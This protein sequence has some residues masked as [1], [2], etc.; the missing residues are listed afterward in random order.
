VATTRL[1][2]AWLTD[3]KAR[4]EA[5]AAVAAQAYRE[6]QAKE[7]EAQIA[8]RAAA[9][10]LAATR[11]R[12]EQ[13]Q[14][15]VSRLARD[16]RP[17]NASEI[18]H[19]LQIPG[20]ADLPPSAPMRV[21]VATALSRCGPDQFERWVDDAVSTDPARATRARWLLTVASTASLPQPARM[22]RP[23]ED[24]SP[25]SPRKLEWRMPE[26]NVAAGSAG[27]FGF[28]AIITTLSIL[29]VAL[30]GLLAIGYLQLRPRIVRR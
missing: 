23:H 18:N 21:A 27:S 30:T 10:Q 17:A 13:E 19:I 1:T 22:S 26:Q 3:R 4:L 20:L 28:E 14:E 7:R 8:S 15:W 5:Q 6:Q 11:A 24:R 16:N 9:N 12:N 2:D 29:T 25:P